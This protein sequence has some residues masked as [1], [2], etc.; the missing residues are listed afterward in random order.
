MHR[1]VAL[2]TAFV[3]VALADVAAALTANL[4]MIRRIAEI[5]QEL[6]LASPI[7]IAENVL[8]GRLPVSRFGMV[9]KRRTVEDTRRALERVGL[10]PLTLAAKEGLAL[11]NGTAVMC[12]LGALESYHAKLLSRTADIA[13]CLSLEAL[14]GTPL[15]FDERIH[16]VRPHPRQVDCAAYLR[17]LIEGR[18]AHEG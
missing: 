5:Y 6:S 8:V 17:R 10:A 3:P 18:E 1:Q 4:R 14:H 9:D 7:S 12:A 2:V 15:A 13:G 16:V 11:T